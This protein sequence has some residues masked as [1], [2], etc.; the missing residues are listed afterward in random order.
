LL[1][2]FFKALELALVQCAQIGGF[3]CT[4][5]RAAGFLEGREEDFGCGLG[6]A[7]RDEFELH[8]IS[9]AIIFAMAPLR[10]DEL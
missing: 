7:G 6:H 8:W 1:L 4:I 9:F 5:V 10:R 3:G 2:I